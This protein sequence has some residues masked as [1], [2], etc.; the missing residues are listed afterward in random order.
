VAFKLWQ[1]NRHQQFLIS[2]YLPW[3]GGQSCCP[4]TD[5]CQNIELVSLRDVRGW[6]LRAGGC[7]INGTANALMRTASR[8]PSFPQLD[9]V[10]KKG[11]V[12]LRLA[13][14]GECSARKLKLLGSRIRS[15]GSLSYLLPFEEPLRAK[16]RADGKARVRS[17][18]KADP[19]SAVGYD[20]PLTAFTVWGN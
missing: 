16:N 9:T 11:A 13:G 10:G 7:A 8:E 5:Q 14:T 17:I 19:H 6:R 1:R 4:S 20:Q 12:A 15:P 18:A 2:R 3:R